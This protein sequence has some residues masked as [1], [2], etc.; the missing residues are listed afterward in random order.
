MTHGGDLTDSWRRSVR[1]AVL[2]WYR[3]HGRQLPWRSSA[4]PYRIWVS[5]IMLQQT[6]VAAVM[7]YFDRFMKRFPNIAALSSAPIEDVL[8]LWEGLGYYS[9]ARNLHAAAQRVVEDF[10]GEFPQDVNAL[11]SLPGIGRYTAGAVASFAFNL[12]APIVEANTVRLFARLTGLQENVKSTAGQKRLW[13]FAEWLVDRNDAASFNQSVMDL[14]AQICRVVDPLCSE[15][16]LRRNC[17]AFRDG[18]QSKI[19]VQPTRR[20][21]TDVTEF[22]LVLHRRR[23]WLVRQYADSERWAGLWDFVRFPVADDAAAGLAKPPPKARRRNE[24]H[25]ARRLFSVAE[26]PAG[27]RRLP[28]SISA[29]VHVRTGMLVE[30]TEPLLELRHV[31]TRYRIQLVVHAA[32]APAG[33]L[34]HA[35]GYQWM[36]TEQLHELAMPVTGRRILGTLLSEAGFS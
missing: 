15:C 9:R 22:A 24:Y 5:E 36:T 18:Q 6:T 4:D 20:S 33:R 17:L 1:Q 10:N 2:K 21:M 31:V 16:P 27:R 23:R 14:G 25:N 7:P 8:R 12:P 29:E 19:P 3:Q 34:R 28:G 26:A 11:R 13:E 30:E 35:S 32:E